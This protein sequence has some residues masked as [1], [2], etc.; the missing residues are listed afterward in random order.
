MVHRLLRFHNSIFNKLM[1]RVSRKKKLKTGVLVKGVDDILIRFGKCCQPVPGDL[2]TGYITRGFGVTVHRTNCVNALK[3]NPERQIDVQWSEE[4]TQSYPVKV[5]LTSLDRVGLLAPN[6][7]RW[8]VVAMAVGLVVTLISSLLPARK[9]A[10]VP[11]V[12]AMREEAARPPSRSL[13]ARAIWGTIIL[14]VGIVMLASGLFLAVDNALL[15][16]GLGALVLFVGVSILLPLASKPIARFIG[17]PLPRMFGEIHA[18][19]DRAGS[20]TC[21]H[22]GVALA[23]LFPANGN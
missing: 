5:K 1:G 7:I 22:T 13:R 4:V 14:A 3:M 11:P 20:Y 23:G 15:L 9:A 8:V 12:A 21:P 10:R 18:A 17:W 2:I 6:G 19:A 16:V